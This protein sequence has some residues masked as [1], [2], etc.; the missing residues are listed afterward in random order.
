MKLI[1]FFLC[2]S[3]SSFA[4]NKK[5]TLIVPNNINFIKIGETVY[6]VKRKVELEEVS[7]IKNGSGLI[8]GGSGTI[9]TPAG[10]YYFNNSPNLKLL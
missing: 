3:A 1:I 4:Q 6:A 10:P 8:F 2:I 7:K 5:D 9:T